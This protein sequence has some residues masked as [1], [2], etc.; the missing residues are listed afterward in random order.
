[1]F[2]D[3]NYKALQKSKLNGANYRKHL[4]LPVQ[5][6]AKFNAKQRK[7]SPAR[8][9]HILMIKYVEVQPTAKV[10]V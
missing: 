10:Y 6:F 3:T 4:Y 7:L 9:L 8:M 2:N 1:M 5:T